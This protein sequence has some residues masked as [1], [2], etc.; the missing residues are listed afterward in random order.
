M[1]CRIICGNAMDTLKH[2]QGNS[3]DCV[4]TSP[5]YWRLRCYSDTPGELGNEGTPQEFVFNLM[6]VFQQVKRVLKP[7]GTIFVNIGET[8]PEGEKSAECIPE[9][10]LVMMRDQLGFFVRNKVRWHKPNTLAKSA[11]DRFALCS[12][13][14]FV[15]SKTKNYYFYRMFEAYSEKSKSNFGKPYTGQAT[16]DYGS[17]GAQDPSAAKRS[18]IESMNKRPGKALR[19][20]WFFEEAIWSV[21]NVPNID[22]TATYPPELVQRCLMAGCPSYV[23]SCCGKPA[24]PVF[25]PSEKYGKLLGETWSPETDGS[26]EERARLGF[27]QTSNKKVCCTS[28]YYHTGWKKC[29]CD[30]P[31][32]PGVV[33]DPFAGNFT[34]GVVAKQMGLDFYLMELSADNCKKGYARLQKTQKGSHTHGVTLDSASHLSRACAR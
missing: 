22:H 15:F 10:F 25:E 2:L 9:R 32:N 28:E 8:Y 18:I 34:T 13:D 26:K 3:V 29:R 17:S 12:E 21:N 23:C 20:V 33:F 5:P 31:F 6:L 19:D 27:T 24:M 7:T 4:V 14:L 11:P 30:A 1:A 16:K